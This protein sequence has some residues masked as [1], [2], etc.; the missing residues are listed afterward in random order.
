MLNVKKSKSNVFGSP[1]KLGD[2]DYDNKFTL[3]GEVLQYTGQYNYLGLILDKHMTLM[4]LLS[5]LGLELQ[6]RSFRYSKF[7]G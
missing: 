2:I 3:H 5:N 7:G 4:P 6:V 1:Y